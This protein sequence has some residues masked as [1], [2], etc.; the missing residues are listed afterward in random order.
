MVFQTF[1]PRPVISAL[2]KCYSLNDLFRSDNSSES[3]VRGTSFNRRK[4]LISDKRSPF[5]V[6][7]GEQML[8]EISLWHLVNCSLWNGSR[9]PLIIII[10]SFLLTKAIGRAIIAQIPKSSWT[11]PLKMLNG[12]ACSPSKNKMRNCKCPRR[13]RLLRLLKSDELVGLNSEFT[14]NKFKSSFD[15]Y[16]TRGR[17]QRIS[18]CKNGNQ[19]I[20]E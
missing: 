2:A 11:I 10:I 6:L 8:F 15:P 12:S 9:Y 16:F 18:V 1:R 3:T 19:H 4:F 20:E 17:N 13:G 7:A 5:L 14:Q